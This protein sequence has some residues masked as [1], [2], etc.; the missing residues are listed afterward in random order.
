MTMK[1]GLAGLLLTAVDATVMA[2]PYTVQ[3]AG[4]FSAAAITCAPLGQSARGDGVARDLANG[5]DGR[6]GRG[7][8]VDI[9]TGPP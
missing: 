6:R 3:R 2:R 8:A 7:G 9:G 1:R 5:G 4:N